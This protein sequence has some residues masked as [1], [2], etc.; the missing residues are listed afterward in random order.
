MGLVNRLRNA[1]GRGTEEQSGES[2][3][4]G[5]VEVLTDKV[6]VYS[7]K[8][9]TPEMIMRRNL[10]KLAS[11]SSDQSAHEKVINALKET[12]RTIGPLA[13]IFFTAGEVFTYI[14]NRM[15]VTDLWSNVLVWGIT[16][17]IEIPFAVATYDLAE[18]KRRKAEAEESGLESPIKD[19]A[20]AIAFWVI[21][22]FVNV[23]GQIA[24][25]AVA[26]KLAPGVSDWTL[27]L[28]VAVRVIGVLVGDA[29]T[30]FYLL[31]GTTNVMRL[32][33]FQKQQT[34]G[35]QSL[36]QGDM[37]LQTAKSRMELDI[38]RNL[39]AM[40][41]E[42]HEADFMHEFSTYNLQ[43]SLEKWKQFQDQQQS[44]IEAPKKKEGEM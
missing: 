3:V 16:L 6:G 25:L 26:I 32:V 40:R 36:V 42:E 12:W 41:R 4:D 28:F 30:A 35:I 9:I 15:G 37:A 31:P 34:E 2:A 44:M 38:K 8:E 13:F 20:G 22:A 14:I 18:R 43:S 5:E 33:R 7:D 23:V 1:V 24:F 10:A 39:L 17:I 21:M 27:Y 11:L 29:Y 19:T